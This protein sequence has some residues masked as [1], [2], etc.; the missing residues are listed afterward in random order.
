MNE[1]FQDQ[2]L[3]LFK[4]A[5]TAGGDIISW[6]MQQAPELVHQL[7]TYQF[8]ENLVLFL[9]NLLLIGFAIFGVKKVNKF[10]KD[11]K[12]NFD[13]MPNRNGWDKPGDWDGLYALHIL[14]A[15][16]IGADVVFGIMH[17]LNMVMI[18]VAP[19]L[20]LLQYFEA[21]LKAHH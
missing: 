12:T 4:K 2:L 17:L 18:K 8:I 5:Q 21:M 10:V 9:V 1:Q 15:G 19:N 13:K 6:L 20:F 3:D 7:L 14:W 16:V 11:Y